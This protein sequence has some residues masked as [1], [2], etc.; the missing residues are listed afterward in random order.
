MND[1]IVALQKRFHGDVQFVA[2]SRKL[3]REGKLTKVCR[4]KNQTYSC[5]V[6]VG[7]CLQNLP[8][9]VFILLSLR[10]ILFNDLLI[11]CRP[12]KGLQNSLKLHRQIP[13]D[14]AFEV[15]DI[16]SRSSDHFPFQIRNASKSFEVRAASHEEKIEWMLALMSCIQSQRDRTGAPVDAGSEA[17]QAPVWQPDSHSACCSQCSSQFT[18]LKRRHHCRVW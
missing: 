15:H 5:V 12:V 18:M 4:A 6:S 11:Y 9:I 3:I 7:V 17:I 10:F 2:P 16:P 1:R 14:G 8:L 13:I